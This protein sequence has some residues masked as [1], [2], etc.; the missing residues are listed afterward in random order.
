M[1]NDYKCDYVSIDINAALT[2]VTQKSK[3]VRETIENM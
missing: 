2:L 1:N 3:I